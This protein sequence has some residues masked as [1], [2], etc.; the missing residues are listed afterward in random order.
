M[1]HASSN[2][3]NRLAKEKSPYLLQ[4]ADNPVDW[5]PWAEEAFEKARQEDKPV[6]LSI[7]YSTCH[8]CHVME[9]ESFEDADIA[10][11]INAH[12]V[13][14]KVD[15]EERP[16][17]D[18]IYMSVVVALTGQGGWP[19]TV[20][21]T[22]DQKPF[23]GGTYFP[24]YA[25]WGSAGLVDV[26]NS[27]QNSW[28]NNRSSIVNSGNSIH[29]FLKNQESSSNPSSAISPAVLRQAFDNFSQNFDARNGGFGGS[30]KFPSAHNLSFLLR[31]WRRFKDDQAR[32]MVEH[33]LTKMAHGGMY[34]HLAGG[35]HRYS[36]DSHWQVPHFEKMLYDQAM[37]SQAYLETFQA[38]GDQFYAHIAREI[39]EYVLRDMR[40]PQGGFYSAE[41]ADSLDPE[42]KSEMKKEGAFYVW[43]SS[44]IKEILGGRD[45]EIFSERYGIKEDGNALEDPHQEFTGKNIIF[46]AKPMKETAQKF[47][48]TTEQLTQSLTESRK[49]LLFKR[50]SR[51]RPHLDD[52]VLTDWNSLMIAAFSYGSRVFANARYLDAAVKGSEFIES[53]LI[54]REGRLLHRYRDGESA[55]LGNLDDYAFYIHALLALYEAALKTEYLLKAIHFT[56]EMIRLFWD[57]Q[58]HGFYFTANDAPE[59]FYRQ[60]ETYDGAVPSGNSFAA[61]NLIKLYHLTL[62]DRWLQILTK[63]SQAFASPIQKRPDGYAQMLSAFDFVLGPAWEFVVVTD[64]ADDSF[65]EAVHEIRQRFMP[66]AV[67]LVKHNHDKN[68]AELLKAVPILEGQKTVDGKTTVYIC[69]SHVCHQPITEIGVLKQKLDELTGKQEG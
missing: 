21:L 26:M 17:I 46:V 9:H 44:A 6:F 15:R 18:G 34:D 36:T 45:A 35:F 50:D 43:K 57:E 7:G 48:I 2:F 67:I 30:P 53:R 61:L 19:L 66:N 24:P 22:P 10:R 13:P 51:P 60:K 63:M 29:E 33:T 65:W 23:F 4:H 20:F 31:C 11:Y 27:V 42:G 68:I 38:T 5:Y 54:N 55:I 14:V 8:W 64:H 47:S 1:N 3:Q 16:D 40:D 59:L 49:K 62:N 58:A 32:A 37:I 56:E 52:K 25:R 12:F 69:E 28:V 39:F 41:D